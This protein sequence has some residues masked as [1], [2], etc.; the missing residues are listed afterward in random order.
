MR[1]NCI[2]YG[3]TQPNLAKCKDSAWMGGSCPLL[4][5]SS[6]L[7]SLLIPNTMWRGFMPLIIVRIKRYDSVCLSEL[8][9][10]RVGCKRKYII[11]KIA[12]FSLRNLSPSVHIWLNYNVVS[13]RFAPKEIWTIPINSVKCWWR[14][15]FDGYIWKSFV[16]LPLQNVHCTIQPPSGSNLPGPSLNC[17]WYIW[18]PRAFVV[19]S[20]RK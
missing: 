19:Y 9:G 13:F 7:L 14:N 5:S 20:R 6:V 1:Y 2:L 10:G 3:P 11:N 15:T 16:P 12:A 8:L 17:I 18:K 4:L